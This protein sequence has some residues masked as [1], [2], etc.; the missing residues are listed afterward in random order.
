LLFGLDI[1]S[2][3]RRAARAGRDAIVADA[4]AVSRVPAPTGAEARRARAVRDLFRRDDPGRLV[5]LD[6]AGNVVT[7][8]AG[9]QR[10]RSIIVAAHLDTVFGEDQEHDTRLEHGRLIGPGV[11]DNAVA[12]AAMVA[13]PRLFVSSGQTPACDVVLVATVGEEGYGNLR[14]IEAALDMHREAAAVIAVEGHGLGRITHVA[15]G[16]RRL[17]VHLVGPGGHSWA[18]HGRPSAVHAAG[19]L[20]ARLAA[21]Q[22]PD[23]PR[24]TLNV[25]SVSGGDAI[26]AIAASATLH[27]E[28]RSVDPL[29]LD[30]A[31][32]EV[33]RH[34]RA[35]ERDGIRVTVETLGT[36]PAGSIPKDHLI[37]RRARSVLSGL[38]V[39]SASDASS[40]DANIPLAS[41][42]PAI[43]VG[44]SNGGQ[45]H[46]P[47]EWIEVEPIADGVAQLALVVRDVAEDVAS[48]RIRRAGWMGDGERPTAAASD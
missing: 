8:I 32:D 17:A 26:N 3:L 1:T 30:Q 21:M 16:S 23:W 40:T 28:A 10:E 42:I 9:R 45:A 20:I 44:I 47:H 11:G 12:L 31:I 18:D 25:G 41:G 34:I 35:V 29:A 38:G 14:G 13:L 33:F 24:T 43:C 5:Y 2:G 22:L 37:V 7:R 19:E 15:V 36:R 48:G 6:Q 27:L 39:P 46:T 4:L